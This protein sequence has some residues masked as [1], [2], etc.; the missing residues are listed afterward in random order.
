MIDAPWYEHCPKCLHTPL[1]NDQALPAACPA[2]G[3]VLAK[4]AAANRERLG[5][6]AEERAAEAEPSDTLIARLRSAATYVPDRVESTRFWGRVLLLLPFSVWGVRLIWMDHRT[7][8]MGSSFLH[9]PL[10]VF[11]EAGHVIFSFFGEFITIL[12]GT[13]AQL[14]MP[15]I[16]A[17]ALLFRNRDP[18]G[19]AI[20]TWLLGVSF[21]DIAPYVYDALHPQLVLLGGHTGEEGGHDW[22][23]L[24]SE[25]GLLQYAHGLGW[26]T[27]KVGALVV[28]L[29]IGWAGWILLGEKRIADSG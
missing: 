21:L 8:E 10:L 5:H 29:S 18:F 20:A 2:C 15:A 4:F 1:P 12:G 19:A 9:G 28:L 22:V 7:G 13:L 24:L 25:T 27:H 23:Y 11:H 14:L 3:L 26:L 17:G 6:D 16:M